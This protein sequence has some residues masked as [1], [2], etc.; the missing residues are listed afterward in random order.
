MKEIEEKYNISREQ[1]TH[2]LWPQIKREKKQRS[3]KIRVGGKAS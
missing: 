1:N 2:D 3:V